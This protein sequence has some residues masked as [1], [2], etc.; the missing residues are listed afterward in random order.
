MC[1][2]S[3]YK[4]VVIL[5]VYA[6]HIFRLLG[7]LAVLPRCLPVLTVYRLPFVE[8]F[9]LPVHIARRGILDV[10]VDKEIPVHIHSSP[11]G[12]RDWLFALVAHVTAMCVHGFSC[13][14]LGGFRGCGRLRRHRRTSRRGGIPPCRPLSQTRG[15]RIAVRANSGN[16]DTPQIRSCSSLHL[17]GSRG[18]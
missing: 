16:A 8:T 12:G 11:L 13:C 3:C 6:S 4:F 14:A 10:E 5:F 17:T 2:L 18:R 1:V 7:E 9:T 15:G